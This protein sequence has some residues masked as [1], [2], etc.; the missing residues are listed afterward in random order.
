MV[1]LDENGDC[2]H[3]QIHREW[4][5]GLSEIGPRLVE[6]GWVRKTI[7]EVRCLFSEAPTSKVARRF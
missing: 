6:P 5:K 2:S 3:R 4:A 7:T 1:G